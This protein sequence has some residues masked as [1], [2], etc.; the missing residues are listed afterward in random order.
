MKKLI[1]RST[2]HKIKIPSGS[3]CLILC[4]DQSD[5]K[6][7]AYKHF[8]DEKIIDFS[9]FLESA[10]D[11]IIVNNVNGPLIW[12]C[13][14]ESFLHEIENALDENLLIVDIS[15]FPFNFKKFEIIKEHFQN[16][17]LIA[18]SSFKRTKHLSL[19]EELLENFDVIYV[20]NNIKSVTVQKDE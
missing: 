2:D 17:I 5:T 8:P 1:A 16:V 7:F 10:R 4:G 12:T 20:T 3:T 19:S 9:D 14:E 6:K 15:K 18:D 13:A 11:S